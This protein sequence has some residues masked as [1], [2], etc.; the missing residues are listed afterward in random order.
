MTT[1]NAL[2]GVAVGNLASAIGWYVRLLGRQPDLRP[3]TDSA[4]W[5]FS[6]GGW[7]RV[8]QDSGRA[9]ASSVTLVETDVEARI[10]D[11][12]A[13]GIAIKQASNSDSVALAIVVDP[14]G[15]QIVFAQGKGPAHRAVA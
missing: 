9:G 13:K 8:F 14:D 2:A 7:I 6:D 15:N 10:A 5:E 4:E 3:M 11:L 1:R 12:K